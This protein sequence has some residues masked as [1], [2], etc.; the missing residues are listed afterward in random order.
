MKQLRQFVSILLY[1]QFFVHNVFTFNLDIL[2]RT[3]GVKW[4]NRWECNNNDDCTA[5]N[6][7]CVDR[8]CQCAR[9]YV[10][11][12][13]MTTCLRIA[14]D[15]Y[16]FCEE[17]VQ[18]SAYLSNGGR[19]EDVNGI[20]DE[21]IPENK[22]GN[23]KRCVCGPG[24]YYMHGRCNRYV[25]LFEE[26]EQDIDCYVNADF[27]ASTCEKISAE[28]KVCKCSPGFY[29]RE[30]RTCRRKAESV[31]DKCVIDI[32]CFFANAT[33][34][35][36]FECE[37]IQTRN[38]S[39][40]ME[41]HDIQLF[42]NNYKN[43]EIRVGSSCVINEDCGDLGNA[44][45]DPFGTCRCERAHFAFNTSAKCVPELG[46]PCDNDDIL[47]PYINYSVCR[48]RWTCMN[49]FVALKNNRECLNVT[50]EYEGECQHDEQCY[51]FG[52]D[53]VCG[54]NKCVCDE[55][56]SH[57]VESELFCWRN[58]GVHETCE[59]EHDCH[60]NDLKGQLV[61]NN[62]CDCFE[63]TKINGNKTICI[64]DPA[65][66]GEYCEED[67]NCKSTSNSVCSNNKCTCNVNDYE[68]EG[69]CEKGINANCETNENCT[70]RNSVCIAEVC[71]C[72]SDYVATAVDSCMPILSFGEPCSVD[73]QCSA[74]VTGA[75]CGTSEPNDA[76]NKVCTC[77]EEDHYSFEKCRKKRFLGETCE[78]LGE[79]YQNSDDERIICRN[80]KCSCDWDYVEHKDPNSVRNICARNDEISEQNINGSV[81]NVASTGLLSIIFFCVF[82]L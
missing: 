60:V 22:S 78:N 79:C 65:E 23:Q 64:S 12:A 68:L 77:S 40:Y 19:C 55:R 26:C 25:G 59:S 73:V 17:T 24:Y 70:V 31:G 32:D 45:C 7:T 74:N 44:I 42:V 53:A 30:Y 10:M 5:M 62:T 82:F 81:T 38:E 72:I 75:I 51:V 57:Y 18:C 9:G 13:D 1:L 52:P 80:G 8:F 71:S 33:C 47:N 27:E 37:K 35:D 43:T 2:T 54:N 3:N 14:T 49:G 21:S 29:Q 66:I 20:E 15:Y 28:R 4:F 11:N 34:N 6:A 61:C 58:K 56:V 76:G 69:R 16:D 50:R 63:G 67:D 39:T 46:E 41:N 48:K 36:N